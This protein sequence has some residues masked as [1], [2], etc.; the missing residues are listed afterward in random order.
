MISS[1][2]DVNPFRERAE[3]AVLFTDH[4][5]GVRHVMFPKLHQI[6]R[7]DQLGENFA[8][9]RR[10]FPDEFDFHPVTY[11][12]PF[13][14]KTLLKAMERERNGLWIVKP[15]NN[16]NGHGVKVISKVKDVPKDNACVQEYIRR[17]LLIRDRKVR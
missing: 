3:D 15:P 17:P 4:H 12:L 1:A 6:T 5:P 8:R 9:M 11:N 13:D 16:N 2:L 7:K 10:A 14:M